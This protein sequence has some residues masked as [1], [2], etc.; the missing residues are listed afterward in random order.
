MLTATT[1]ITALQPRIKVRALSVSEIDSQLI[2]QW[3]QLE[4][5]AV[6][7][8]PFLSPHFVLPAIQHLTPKMEVVLLVFES[9]REFSSELVGLGI[10]ERS[11]G[12][13]VA[14]FPHLSAYAT[15]GDTFL[16]NLLVDRSCSREVLTSFFEFL[17]DQ[18]ASWQCVEF[19]QRSVDSPF[20][21][22]LAEVAGEFGMRWIGWEFARPIL[23]P[24]ETTPEQVDASLSRN[25]RK[26]VRKKRRQLESLGEVTFNIA[27]C[28][29]DVNLYAER[30]LRLEDMGWKGE[31]KSSLKSHP[32]S[33]AFFL[34]MTA[35]FANAN[36]MVFSELRVDDTLGRTTNG[37]NRSIREFT[38]AELK[39]FDAGSWFH[40][41]FADVRVPTLEETFA[42]IKQRRCRHTIIALNVKD[43]TRDG[44]KRLV[45]LVEEYGL[46]T[47]SFLFDQSQ[48]SSHRLNRLNPNVR[49]GSNVSRKTVE[50]RL[51]EGLLDVFLVTFVPTA[52]EVQRLHEHKK[53]V[54]YNFGGNDKSR[55]NPS[56]WSKAKQSGTDGMLTDFSLECRL[57]WR[58]TKPADE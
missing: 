4:D 33:E 58:H 44:E 52:E 49:I 8:N 42:L 57:H 1:E 48:E 16:T 26:R 46:L 22:E 29:P 7:P 50:S 28:G 21:R 43:I 35:K 3:E 39:T 13:M 6:E 34:E 18:P 55:R 30:F 25:R 12:T 19:T 54:V 45:E 32:E 36:R 56:A 9:V 23:R 31:A 40:P 27:H 41:R 53:Q 17:A 10:F 47:E 24:G 14:P 20:G 5:R 37:P 51:K 38:L 15:P 2:D 11:R